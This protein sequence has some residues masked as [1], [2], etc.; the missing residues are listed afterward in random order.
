MT[1]DAAIAAMVWG[2]MFVVGL[3]LTGDDF[4]RMVTQPR[5]VVAGT[6]GP[7]LLLPLLTAG[8]IGSGHWPPPVVAGLI[9]LAAGP[10]GALAN[11]YAYL[12]GAN[13]ALAVTLTAL[14]CLIAV[15]TLPLLT[16][17]GFA[18]WLAS[19]STVAVPIGPMI[20]QLLLLLLLP[21]SV[22]MTVRYYWPVWT[23]RRRSV[24]QRLALVG[25]LAL[26]GFVLYD[27]ADLLRVA[28]RDQVG[29]ALL[30]TLLA[31]AAGWLVG[32]FSGLESRDRF[33]LL[34]EFAVRNLAIATLVAVTLLGRTDFVAFAA[35]LFLV[36]TPLLLLAVALYRR[37]TALPPHRER[38]EP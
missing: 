13:A 14:S 21:V 33:T 22:G 37:W 4:R 26:L 20:G 11:I 1:L 2:L 6:L 27:Q 35:V 31:M 38:I 34:G 28:W 16:R 19:D 15:V 25:L 12:A 5:A 10:S 17:W 32:G 36:Q 8:L 23:M 9:L 18:L 3:E 29:A 24:A 30:F 7:L